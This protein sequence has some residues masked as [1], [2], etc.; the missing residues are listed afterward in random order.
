MKLLRSIPRRLVIQPM[1]DPVDMSRTV[2]RGLSVLLNL[3]FTSGGAPGS[4]SPLT[5]EKMMF[6]EGDPGTTVV[7]GQVEISY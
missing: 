2:S 1:K 7:D 6:N 4:I 3:R 5:F